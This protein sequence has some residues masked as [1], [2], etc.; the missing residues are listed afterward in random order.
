MKLKNFARLVTPCAAIV[1]FAVGN[2]HASTIAGSIYCGISSNTPTLANLSSV[3][4]SANH[5]ADF[6][7]TEI[8]FQS[9]P[10]AYTL[11]GFLTSEGAS[12]GA[13]AFF[14][15]FTGTSS[16]NNTL[17]VF[18]GTAYFQNGQTFTVGHDDGTRMYVGGN[19]VLDQPGPT[20]FATSTYTYTGVTGNQSFEFL[21]S[22]VVGLP[23]DYVTTLGSAPSVPEPGTFLLLGS[24]LL[25]A[26]GA[27]RRRMAA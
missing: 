1:L 18:T 2:A 22:E 5:C 17:F 8:N 20:S 4:T 13:S 19:L 15:G 21:Y 26:A 11:N 10:G 3:A 6:N 23:A 7:A 25:G 9:P 16:L 14:N 27:I 24:G 12:T